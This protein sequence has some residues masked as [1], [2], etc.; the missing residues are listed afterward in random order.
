MVLCL[1]YDDRFEADLVNG[2]PD[3][4][5]LTVLRALTVSP[6]VSPF[7]YGSLPEKLTFSSISS[8]CERQPS[9]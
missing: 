3:G 4:N 7:P 1:R 8:R 9:P 6:Q 2:E 5:I